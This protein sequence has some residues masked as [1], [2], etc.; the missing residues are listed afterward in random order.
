MYLDLRDAMANP[1]CKLRHNLAVL[2]TLIANQVA[3]RQIK[4]G[5]HAGGAVGVD[6]C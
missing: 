3:E 2:S 1:S 5:A 4:T 6:H